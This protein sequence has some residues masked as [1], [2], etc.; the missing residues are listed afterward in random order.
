M[1]LRTSRRFSSISLS[2]S[3]MSC[4]LCLPSANF[5][6]ACLTLSSVSFSLS[7]R[8]RRIRI[9]GVLSETLMGSVGIRSVDRPDGYDAR[10]YPTSLAAILRYVFPIGK[11]HP[12][13]FCSDLLRHAA[14]FALASEGALLPLRYAEPALSPLSALPRH[15]APRRPRMGVLPTSEMRCKVTLFLSISACQRAKFSNF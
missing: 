13:A 10:H 9:L 6:K 2:N 8:M 15:K 7:S 12:R 3:W 11:A 5:S 4:L 14:R 1:S